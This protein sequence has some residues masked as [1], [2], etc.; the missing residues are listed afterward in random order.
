MENKKLTDVQFKR[1]SFLQNRFL[2][3]RVIF[4]LTKRLKNRKYLIYVGLHSFPLKY[5][6]NACDF[7]FFLSTG[8]F[9]IFKW[10]LFFKFSEKFGYISLETILGLLGLLV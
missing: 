6:P 4:P 9:F 8:F 7:I 3:Y 10:T 5:F 2:R 1:C